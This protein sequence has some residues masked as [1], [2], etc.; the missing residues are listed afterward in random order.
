M[1]PI[2]TVDEA[3][4]ADRMVQES[5]LP[6]AA[7]LATAGFQLAR[8]VRQRWPSGPWVILTGPGANG[9][10]GWV[11][12]RHLARYGLTTVVPI[13]EPAFPDSAGWV[14]Q[15]RAAGAEIIRGE[16][17]HE[18]MRRAAVVVDA[19]YGTGFHGHVAESPAGP[20]LNF[21]ADG[22]IP[23]AAADIASG[24]NGDTG[25]YEGPPVT[26]A[27]TV[28]MGAAKWGH[29]GYPGADFCPHLVIADVGL[30][31]RPLARPSGEFIE[32]AWAASKFPRMSL[33]AHKYTR[34][35]VVI[36]GGSRAMPGAPLLAGLAALTAG[37]GLVE[38][39]MP[40]SALTSG[41]SFSP[42]LIVHPADETADGSLAWGAALE[43]RA[44]RA[45]AVVLGPGLGEH[46]DRNLLAGLLRLAKPTVVDADG[47]RLVR[48]AAKLP[49]NW[50]LTPHARELGALLNKQAG[51]IDGDRR[52]A[53]LEATARFGCPIL[54][55]GR[56]SL[57]AE[58]DHVW[59]NP[60][61]NPSL[62]TAGSGDVLSGMAARLM[63]AGLAAA[64]ALALAC[65]WHG[66]TADC[67]GMDGVGFTAV[68]LAG[69]LKSGAKAIVELRPPVG[70]SELV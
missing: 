64:D 17:A 50:V 35:H 52:A 29:V 44:R 30:A 24:V 68:E 12:A 28:A 40:Q 51:D 47:L 69:S 34:G 66:W 27:L 54:L 2:W 26:V 42:A 19:M 8:A 53:V 70:V 32:P 38:V 5:G 18:R 39:V 48:E 67:T 65:Y 13:A 25:A 20:W 49:E 9:G 61:G 14:S 23:V 43:S 59:V 31:R 7:L 41:V 10:D 62:A 60:T 15:A 58:A 55:K 16:E 36:A 6:L 21:L 33:L 63:A 57:V 11:A 22:Q 45:D 3:R 4:L 56:F 46:P 1:G 37:A